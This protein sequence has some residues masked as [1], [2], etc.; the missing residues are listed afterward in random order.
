MLILDELKKND[1]HLRLVAG[2]LAAGF[3][4]LLAGLWWVQVVSA[5]KY[6]GHLETQSYRTV[7]LPAMRG[8]ILDREGQVL[9]ENR[10][11]YNLSLYL[12]DLRKQFKAASDAEY[13]SATNARARFIAA[14]EKQLG[15]PLTKAERKKLAFT[16]AQMEQLREQG[17]DRVASAVIAQV[18]QKLGQP[19]SLNAAK[20]ERDYKTR[21]AMPYT[22]VPDASPEQVARFEEQMNG[23]LGADVDL[24]PVR[25]YP[26]GT[27]AGHIL[28]TL[29]FDD[30]SQEGEDPVFD[31]R[32]PDYRGV[33]GIEWGFDPV[34][35]GRA[36]GESV[37]VNNYGYRQSENIWSQPE[38]GHN[39]VL[40][41]DLDIQQAAE[42]SL[43]DHQGKEARGAVVVMD[44][45]TGD[46]LAMVSSPALNPD[47]LANDPKY[48]ADPKLSPEVNRATQ[49]SYIPDTPGS[50]FKPIVGLAALENGL[51]PNQVYDVQPDPARPGKGCIYVGKRKIED[52]VP[53]GPYKFRDAIKESSNSYFI[54]NGLRTGIEKIVRLAEKFHFGKPMN[55]P[56][57]QE[58]KGDF[59]TL[60]R[61]NSPSWHDG[62]SANICFG[63][64]EV[65]V[66]PMQMAVAYSA[67]AN[68]GKV[69]WPR[70]VERIEPQNP[71]SG[72]TVTNFP[73][74]LV[75]DEIGVKPSSLN[76]LREAMLSETEDP[77]GTGYPAFHQA[78]SI[79]KLRVCGKTGTAQVKDEH[80]TLT[81]YN[82]W[83]AS[84]APYENPKY[85]V[86]VM[87]QSSYLHGSGGLVCAPIAHD[88]YAKILEKE[89]APGSKYLAALN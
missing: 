22:V 84:F 77:G 56:T 61:V 71:A 10:P 23:S 50:V 41:I 45:R 68:G 11:R 1:P 89:S 63:Q 33:T 27:S 66:T 13:A 74:G 29:Q 25:S 16:T 55:L 37:L 82:F 12:D 32:L 6:Q 34:L 64:G 18:G 79:L 47:Y 5:R 43:A 21:L 54:Y 58:S 2:M 59:P 35:R 8:K 70:L 69:L 52:T 15:R 86:V 73:S 51:D 87:V 75:R 24:Q 83:F 31:Y 46:V 88:I 3:F 38:P 78:D 60:E 53:P 40:T 28:G 30:E 65:T 17:R 19:L 80:G 20:F 85:A 26:H 81:S 76:I 9:A 62:D 72:G 44:V 7:R 4:I 39:V 48:L 57:R 42:K 49:G 14:Q 36:G 67:I